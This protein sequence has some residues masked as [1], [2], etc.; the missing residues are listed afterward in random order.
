[1]RRPDWWAPLGALVLVTV[2]WHWR[3]A[4]PIA[5]D[6]LIP[7]LN[8]DLYA[9][10]YPTVRFGFDELRHGHFPLW[11]PYQ[12]AGLPF[13]ATH[14]HGLLYPFNALHFFL[15]PGLAFKWTA[16]VHYTMALIF[17]GYLGRVLGLSSG[18]I[19]VTAV[20]YAFSGYL[21]SHLYVRTWLVGAVWLPLAWALTI[22][23]FREQSPLRPALWLA[24]VFACQYLGG[25]PL[26]NMLTGYSVALLAVWEVAAMARGGRWRP[27]TNAS[28]ALAAAL[29]IAGA[30]SAVQLLPMMEMTALSPRRLG[31]LSA[32]AAD[33]FPLQ[34]LGQF[35]SLFFPLF[36]PTAAGSL[37]LG[38]TMLP[39]SALAL[40][41]PRLRSRSIFFLTL[42]LSAG[43]LALG[44]LTPAYRWYQMLPTSN[45]FRFPAEFIWLATGALAC[46][47]GI[48]AEALMARRPAGRW[49]ALAAAAAALILVAIIIRFHPPSPPL[50]WIGRRTATVLLALS[51]P[52]LMLASTARPLAWAGAIGALWLDLAL[53]FANYALIPDVAP[54]HF[55]APASVID[56]L[57]AQPDLPRSHFHMP[58]PG[59]PLPKVGMRHHLYAITDH[60]SLIPSRYA[61]Y[62]AWAERAAPPQP[63]A[64]PQG[65]LI[66]DAQRKQMR[67][68]D[69][70]GVRHIVTRTN[71]PF[72]AAEAARYRPVFADGE[73]TVHENP[74]ALPRAFVVGHSEVTDPKAM[75]G[76][77][78]S[79]SFEPL[80]SALVETE[81][82]AVTGGQSRAAEITE[83]APEYV[84]IRVGGDSRGLLVLTDQFY[85]GWEASVDGRP[86][87]IYRADYVFRGVPVPAGEHTVEFRFVPRSFWL[88]LAVSGTTLLVLLAVAIWQWRPGASPQSGG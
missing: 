24:T 29:V 32:A 87:A 82:A 49:P 74:A 36:T 15:E 5:H 17:A 25:Y 72:T 27:A 76:R 64:L 85:P 33:P 50:D 77:L 62:L 6:S 84:A 53:G 42:A 41:H 70:L 18:G 21:Q 52:A 11:N 19:L 79:R 39:F 14:Q 3:V 56:F 78:S 43:V 26:Y 71:T 60:E 7:F 58:A 75:L 31:S 83:Y 81:A 66:L 51:I 59:A 69:L 1:M 67:L 35:R 12:L 9:Y 23:M 38:A 63:V 4:G 57:R 55:G 54:E 34:G 80:T 8:Y 45:W 73:F 48:G 46:T 40:F 13:F 2:W 30:L 20:T 61:E 44:Q 28:A 86:A 88:G 22:R 37:Y 68:L 65:R 16:I 10:Y 47:A